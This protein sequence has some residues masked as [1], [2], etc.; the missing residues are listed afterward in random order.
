MGESSSVESELDGGDEVVIAGANFHRDCTKYPA[1]AEVES[2]LQQVP[3]DSSGRG[4]GEN[5]AA[6]HRRV[7]RETEYPRPTE[8]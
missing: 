5:N 3:D 8:G 7:D 6:D 2:H 1:D 4:S